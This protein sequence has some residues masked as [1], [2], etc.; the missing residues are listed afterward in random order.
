MAQ[1]I[2]GRKASDVPTKMDSIHLCTIRLGLIT[3]RWIHQTRCRMIRTTTSLVVHG[4]AIVDVL[5]RLA[6]S[7]HQNLCLSSPKALIHQVLLLTQ[8]WFFKLADFSPTSNPYSQ[9][10][11]SSSTERDNVYQLQIPAPKLSTTPTDHLPK[12][13]FRAML[14]LIPS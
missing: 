11:S 13:R 6:I 5:A 14:R 9:L 7:F 4:K 8:A 3:S 2:D 10:V 1:R 12:S